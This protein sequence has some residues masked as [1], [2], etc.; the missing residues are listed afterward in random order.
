[1][2]KLLIVCSFMVLFFIPMYSSIYTHEAAASEI[3]MQTSSEQPKEMNLSPKSN[4]D[5]QN[6]ANR[7]SEDLSVKAHSLSIPIL[8]ICLGITAALFLIGILFRK[9]LGVAAVSLVITIVVFFFLQDTMGFTE[10][11]IGMVTYF[12]QFN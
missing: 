1:M 3:Q 9:V 10:T 11:L 5:I 4:V 7:L 8:L 6:S 2:R 12:K